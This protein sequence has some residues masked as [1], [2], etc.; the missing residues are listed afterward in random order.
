MPPSLLAITISRGAAGQTSVYRPTADGHWAVVNPSVLFP[1]LRPAR[2]E[3]GRNHQTSSRFFP[4][5]AL[6][7]MI[8]PRAAESNPTSNG[9]R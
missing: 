2:L 9:F 4:G 1:L 3:L 7:G 6:I 5:M 8:E